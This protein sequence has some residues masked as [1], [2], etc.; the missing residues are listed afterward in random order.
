MLKPMMILSKSSMFLIIFAFFFAHLML[1]FC[2]GCDCK[3]IIMFSFLSL[4][5]SFMYRNY[6]RHHF[7]SFFTSFFISFYTSFFA[8]FS[9]FFHSEREQGV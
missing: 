8:S 1:I 5:L 6:Y 2:F 9:Y 3:V 7:L 4:L